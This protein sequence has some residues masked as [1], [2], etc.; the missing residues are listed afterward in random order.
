MLKLALIGIM[1]R[2]VN[3]MYLT[4]YFDTI[5]VNLNATTRQFGDIAFF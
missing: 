1:L 4:L 2:G 3:F 5:G